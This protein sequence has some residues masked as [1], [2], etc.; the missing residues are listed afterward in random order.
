MKRKLSDAST[1]GVVKQPRS[2]VQQARQELAQAAYENSHTESVEHLKEVVPVLKQLRSCSTKTLETVQRLGTADQL[3]KAKDQMIAA[4]ET[5]TY[6]IIQQQKAAARVQSLQNAFVLLDRVPVTAGIKYTPAGFLSAEKYED[7]GDAHVRGLLSTLLFAYLGGS[8]A[9]SLE[10]QYSVRS[11]LVYNVGSK[12]RSQSKEDY[13]R[14]RDGFHLALARSMQCLTGMP[15]TA[16]QQHD[17]KYTITI[18]PP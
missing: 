8:N 12:V 5:Q 6:A 17:G 3:R 7:A 16:T 1:T 11:G 9:C 15:A 2:C 14:G 10:A 18:T 4:I 13:D